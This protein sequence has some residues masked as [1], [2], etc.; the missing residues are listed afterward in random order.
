MYLL[1]NNISILN[2]HHC[3]LKILMLRLILNQN[4]FNQISHNRIT[5]D[6]KEA[7]LL[8]LKIK[9]PIIMVIHHHNKNNDIMKEENKEKNS[10]G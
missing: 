4:K 9:I 7:N 3:L 8:D 5:K 1:I 6:N 10:R 2:A